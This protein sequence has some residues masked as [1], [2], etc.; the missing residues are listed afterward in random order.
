MIVK[1]QVPLM[2][3]GTDWD[4]LVYDETRSL[5]RMIPFTKEV[6]SAV[7]DSL[8]AYFNASVSRKGTLV[9]DFDNKL[10]EQKW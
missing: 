8:K 6:S 2:C 7:G 4:C 10:P 3:S 5:Q 1:V 9:I